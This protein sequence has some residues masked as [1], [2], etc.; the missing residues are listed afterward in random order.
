M[1]VGAHL[2]FLG[3]KGWSNLQLI[4]RLTF[5]DV[6]RQT[7]TL[8]MCILESETLN[9]HVFEQWEEAAV[10]SVPGGLIPRPFCRHASHL[11]ICMY[12]DLL[13]C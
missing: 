5:K 6:P 12:T 11:T 4:T 7:F 3:P 1:G 8:T 2:S 13:L 9:M 10:P